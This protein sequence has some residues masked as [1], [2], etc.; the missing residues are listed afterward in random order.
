MEVREVRSR[1]RR[2]AK[3]L[4]LGGRSE[5]LERNSRLAKRKQKELLHR[6]TFPSDFEGGLR[7]LRLRFLGLE[8]EDPGQ[9]F[10]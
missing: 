10:G 3:I 8:N 4:R 9:N 6:V 2:G 5:N 1:Q 7:F